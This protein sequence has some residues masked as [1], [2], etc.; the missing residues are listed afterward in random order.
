MM[1][2]TVVLF[3]VDLAA[4]QIPMTPDRWQFKT[5]QVKFEEYKSKTAMHLL[6]NK[7]LAVLKDLAFTNGT[8][9]FDW[10]PEDEFFAAMYFRWKDTLET[11]C[12]YLRVQAGII[13]GAMQAVQYAPFIK[14]I[15]L[16]DLLPHFQGP[17]SFK[18]GEWNHIKLVISGA[19]MLAYVNDMERPAIQVPRLEGNTSSGSLAFDGK[20]LIA[21]LVVKADQ[22][23]GLTATEDFDPTYNDPRYLR[24]WSVSQATPLP[25]QQEPFFFL[26]P[27]IETTWAPVVAERRGL[28]N[29][30][31]LYGGNNKDRKMVWLKTKLR[32]NVAQERLVALGFSDEIWVYLN[33]RL[34]Y[35]DKNL[36]GYPGSKPPLGR[37]SIEN[38]SFRLPLV[39]GDNEVLVALAANFY[40]WG[41]IARLD[42]MS[43][44][45]VVKE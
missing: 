11:E 26:P 31:R 19:R 28:V 40:G 43:G 23:E 29:I 20:G 45:E 17:A 36:F 38:S 4:Q 14:G 10:A 35:A 2:L 33:G 9:E 39:Q 15:N 27:K 44:I 22:T 16:W 13:P 18:K 3:Y 41:L 42:L 12:F 6:H 7:E 5:G 8:I 25:A 32:A 37:C 1:A 30:T 21:N 24:Q 34:V